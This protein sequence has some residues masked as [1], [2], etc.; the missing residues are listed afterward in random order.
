MLLISMIRLLFLFFL[1]DRNVWWCCFFYFVE[2]LTAADFILK[3]IF[4]VLSPYSWVSGSYFQFALSG[5]Q[6]QIWKSWSRKYYTAIVVNN[7]TMLQFI[8][9]FVFWVILVTYNIGY[10]YIYIY[11]VNYIHS[12]FVIFNCNVF[13]IL[14]AKHFEI[15]K[16][17]LWN[18]WVDC[19]IAGSIKCYDIFGCS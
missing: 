18:W 17:I 1:S 4:I 15:W 7:S 10:I 3:N 16:N 12:F 13:S 19:F 9:S 11:K 5:V 2:T 6:D 14:Q 8:E